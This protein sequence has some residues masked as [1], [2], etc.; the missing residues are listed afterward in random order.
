MTLISKYNIKS[1]LKILGLVAVL[2]VLSGC[3]LLSVRHHGHGYGHS[4]S[5]SYSSSYGN[6][7]SHQG[8]RSVS[9][10]RDY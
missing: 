1:L 4:Y 3:H 7:G 6:H 9:H 10:S 5:T 8:R 2:S